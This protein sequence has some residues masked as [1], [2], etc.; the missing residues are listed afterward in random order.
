M[1]KKEHRPYLLWTMFLFSF[2]LHAKR[3]KTEELKLN[4]LADQAMLLYALDNDIPP[5]DHLD[6]ISLLLF[7]NTNK[8]LAIL[9]KKIMRNI[10]K[11]L[12][13]YHASDITLYAHALKKF[14][15]CRM[16]TKKRTTRKPDIFRTHDTDSSTSFFPTTF[17]LV[18]GGIILFLMVGIFNLFEE[19]ESMKK[20]LEALR[21]AHN[22][23]AELLKQDLKEISDNIQRLDEKI[24]RQASS[25]P[26]MALLRGGQI[27]THDAPS[28]DAKDYDPFKPP[29]K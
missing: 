13:P 28:H 24:N 7:S 18:A 4:K 12:Q 22:G 29:K 25:H 16:P 19:Y 15:T 9:T 10:C 21:T 2:L 27:I 17:T 20:Q 23:N 14:D 5:Q 6:E 1:L 3:S 26:L 11:E 8:A